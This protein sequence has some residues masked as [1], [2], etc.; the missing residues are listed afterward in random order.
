MIG[1]GEWIVNAGESGLCG[2]AAKKLRLLRAAI[3]QCP[4]LI[5]EENYCILHLVMMVF[6]T[7]PAELYSETTPAKFDLISG[8]P[9]N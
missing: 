9:A 1:R 2:P 8:M 3:R 6:V 7:L 4:S 5:T